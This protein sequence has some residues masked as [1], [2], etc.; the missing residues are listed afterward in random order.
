MK[1]TVTIKTIFKTPDL[2]LKATTNVL[3]NDCF[4]IRNVKLID[5][6][7]GPFI[8]M[9]SYKDKNGVWR[10]VCYPITSECRMQIQDAVIAAYN[11][12]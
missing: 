10:S 6:G 1:L 5:N 7:S 4:V 9:P 2:P 3:I 11:E 12:A 8:S